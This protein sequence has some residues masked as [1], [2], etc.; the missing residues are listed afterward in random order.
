MS[1]FLRVARNLAHLATDTI[2]LL[3]R[4]QQCP[5]DDIRIDGGASARMLEA[6]AD[7]IDPL[8]DAVLSITEM[9]LALLL[10]QTDI[11][12]ASTQRAVD[13]RQR[14]P[15]GADAS[16]GPGEARPRSLE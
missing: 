11:V 4:T 16:G 10:S 6:E 8:H 3:D 13:V 7:R 15:I 12:G 2:E 14:A 1:P 5:F 9:P